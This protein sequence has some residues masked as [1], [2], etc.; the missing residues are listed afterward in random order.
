MLPARIPPSESFSP[1]QAQREILLWTTKDGRE[2]PLD[3]MSDDHI[4]NAVRVLTLWKSRARKRDAG[5][6]VLRELA[7]A[8]DRFKRIMRQRRKL[9]AS[10]GDDAGN[11]SM[12]R[13]GFRRR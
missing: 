2:I 7:D 5:D 12:K 4:A 10:E 13:L 11:G 1:R 6:P 3:E 8:I 9:T